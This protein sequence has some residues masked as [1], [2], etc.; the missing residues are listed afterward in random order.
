MLWTVNSE[1]I[2]WYRGMPAVFD[3]QI[4]RHQAGLPVVGVQHVDR[5][6]QQADG[7]QHGPAEKDEPLAIVDVVLAVDAVELVAIE[8]LVLLD[9]ID[10][11]LAAGQ[12][13][14]GQVAR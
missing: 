12:R 4:G 9:E 10:R 6:V 5:Q 7:L 8:V 13:G 3:L 2:R 11:H 1:A 14:C